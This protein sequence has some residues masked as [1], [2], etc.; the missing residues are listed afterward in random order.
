M[1]PSAAR[2]LE[3]NEFA[4]GWAVAVRNETAHAAAAGASV[5]VGADGGSVARWAAENPRSAALSARAR[6]LF[7]GGVTHDFENVVVAGD[8]EHLG[9]Q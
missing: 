1:S 9:R 6:H 3:G 4:G 8:V 5:T 2:R 7:P